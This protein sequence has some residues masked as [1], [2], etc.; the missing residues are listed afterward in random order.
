MH[1]QHV[2]TSVRPVTSGRVACQASW[3]AEQF[4]FRIGDRVEVRGPGPWS[5]G[6]VEVRALS[7]RDPEREAQASHLAICWVVC[8][9]SRWRGSL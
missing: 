6:V 7:D 2:A 3:A 9:H 5:S 4:G 8:R 1:G